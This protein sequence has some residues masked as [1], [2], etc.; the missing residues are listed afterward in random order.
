MISELHLSKSES[1]RV[2]ICDLSSASQPHANSVEISL[3]HVP[4]LDT[5]ETGK[6]YCISNRFSRGGRLRNTLCRS[7]D[8]AIA[9][10]QFGFDRERPARWLRMLH[11]AVNLEA[12]FRCEYI[13]RTR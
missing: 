13:F 3:L 8:S 4:Q 2:F 1:P 12:G 7:R 9:I 10:K 11:E 6:S 5:A